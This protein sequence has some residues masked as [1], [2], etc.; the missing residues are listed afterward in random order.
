[1]GQGTERVPTTDVKRFALLG[2]SEVGVNQV[3]FR[4][5]G[6]VV[7]DRVDKMGR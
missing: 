3:A 5:L 6:N 4:S 1:M 7:L 2:G